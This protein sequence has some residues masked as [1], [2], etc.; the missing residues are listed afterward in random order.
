M[1]LKEWIINVL[2]TKKREL[3]NLQ[4]VLANPARVI[5]LRY[6]NVSKDHTAVPESY[7][8]LRV[9]YS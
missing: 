8:V 5:I 4:K 9:S 3:C 2:T 1:L 6:I 7:T